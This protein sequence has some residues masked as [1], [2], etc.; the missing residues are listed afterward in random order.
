MRVWNTVSSSLL[1]SFWAEHQVAKAVGS[2]VVD[3]Q[4][5]QRNRM[6]RSRPVGSGN[7]R[8]G[9]Y[10]GLCSQPGLSVVAIGAG[11]VLIGERSDISGA[12]ACP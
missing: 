5:G 4:R 12:L 9:N 6:R 2:V 3:E 1:P 10:L 7:I 8:H 11:T